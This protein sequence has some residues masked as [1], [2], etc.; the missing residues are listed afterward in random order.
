MEIKERTDDNSSEKIYQFAKSIIKKCVVLDNDSNQVFALIENNG[1]FETIDLSNSKTKSWLRFAYYEYAGKNHSEE[2]YSNV[3]QLIKAEAIHGG[4]SRET[5]YNR[6]AMFHDSLYYDL[7]TPDWL[8]LKV[9]KD[10]VTVIPLTL[11]TPIFIRTQSQKEQ[12]MPIFGNNQALSDLVSLIRIPT[13]DIQIFK[14]H[15][16]SLFLEG[17]PIPIISVIGEHG[18][19]KSTISKS[20]KQLVDPSGAQTISLSTNSEN[21][22][23]SFHNRYCVCFDNVSKIDQ[24]ISDILCKAVTGDGNA[25]RKLYTDSDEVIYDYK[26]KIIL[27]GIAPNLEFPDLVD[28][29]ITYTTEKISENERITETE[30]KAKLDKLIPHVLGQIFQTLSGAMMIYDSV[31]S[32]LKQL[33]RMA[34]FAIWGECISRVLGYE[35]FS[36]TNSYK[37]K[38]QSHSLDIVESYPIISIVDDLLKDRE[39]YENTVQGF[40]NTIKTHA[41]L[42]GIDI[43]S[44][45]VNFP[46]AANKVKEHVTRLKQN[47]RTIGLEIDIASYTKRDGKHPRNRQIIYITKIKNTVACFDDPSLPSLPSLTNSVNFVPDLTTD[48]HGNHG[49]D[50]EME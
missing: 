34:D 28:R 14:V 25:K 32:E 23:L 45:H 10:S 43:N 44:R 49:N 3:L 6:I 1:H 12:F 8:A 41:E 37:D 31:K 2:M 30:F 46:K 24:V 7:T 4:A 18:S 29:N 39:H 13:Q 40:Y 42:S 15:L 47:F 9:T 5:V 20:I 48:R 19:I 17:F 36:F 26:R 33:P 21:L 22:I 38:I 11:T 16:I 27:N 50:K 35:P